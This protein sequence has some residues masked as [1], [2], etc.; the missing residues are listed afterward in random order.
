MIYRR[1][2]KEGDY[3]LGSGSNNFY[4]DNQAVSQAVI[5]WLKL[6]KGEWWED[7]NN[8]L[9]LWQ[10]ILGQPGSEVNRQSVDN[11]IQDRIHKLTLDN[12]PLVAS[13]DNYES[14]WDNNNRK[15]KFTCTVTT[16]YSQSVTI[17]ES[18]SIG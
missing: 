7:V 10:S 8:G 12:I 3:V 13:I 14:T 9:P 17:Q 6:L 2:D 16:I 1:L 18:L 15:Y 11:I 5:T 4:K